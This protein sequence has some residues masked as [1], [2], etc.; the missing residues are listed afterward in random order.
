LIHYI[1]PAGARPAELGRSNTQG[2]RHIAFRVGDIDAIVARIRAAGIPLF[3]D[4]Q[5]VPD[6]QVTYAAGVRKRLVYF[7]DPEGNLLELCEYRA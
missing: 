2:I 4:V 5:M 3:S 1:S 7:H 6:S